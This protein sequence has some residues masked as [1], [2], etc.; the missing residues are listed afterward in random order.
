MANSACPQCNAG[1]VPGQMACGRCGYDFIKGANPGEWVSEDAS[2]RRV[3]MIGLGTGVAV[4]VGGLVGFLVVREPPPPP[5]EPCLVAVE[6]LRATVAA[7]AD[8]GVTIPSCPDTPPGSVSCWAPV[9]LT[10]TKMPHA[11][12]ERYRLTATASGFDIECRVDQD[13]DGED[14]L[15]RATKDVAVVRITPD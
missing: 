13:K 5:V 3:Q 8:S 10:L 1:V 11:P 14:A 2:R 7:A 6:S 15:Y 12:G 4:L 9:G